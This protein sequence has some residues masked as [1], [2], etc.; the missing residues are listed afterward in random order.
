MIMRHVMESARALW[1][2]R[3]PPVTGL[4]LLALVAAGCGLTPSRTPRASG[5][6]SNGQL[7][8]IATL[9]NPVA[10]QVD[11]AGNSFMAWVGPD[12]ELHFA[13]LNDRAE[14][15]AQGPLSLDT[16][17][18]LKPQLL[19]DPTGQ[20]HLTWLDRRE[21]GLQLL[22]ARLSVDGEVIQGATALSPP[23][24]RV[25]HRSIV[26]DPIGQTIELLWSDNTPIRPGCYH[27]ALDWSGAI[28]AP[29]NMLIPE[30]ILPTAQID[31][32]GFVHL[33]WKRER[34]QEKPGFHYAVYDP[35]R[36]MLGP[37]ILVSEPVAQASVI[38]RPTAG[39][40]FDGP[41]LGLDEDSVYLAWVLEV[42]EMGDVMDFTFYQAFSPP[43]LGQ[44]SGTGTFDYAPP[45]VTEEAVP[46]LGVEPSLT[47]HP[48]FLEGQP[49]RQA[50]ACY[51]EVPG[52][53]NVETLQIAMIEVQPG[54]I[55]RQEI[56][57][58][59]RGASVRPSVVLDPN[60]ELHLA[61]I[62]T[63]GF[64]RYQV[65]YASTSPQARETLNQITTYE[66]VDTVLSTLMQVLSAL[67]FVPLVLTWMFVP[68]GWLVIFA[69]VT[70][71]SEV[72]EPRAPRALVLAMLLHL[73]AKLL[74]LPGILTR[75][76]LSTLLP[77]FLRLLLGRWMLPLLLAIASAALLRAYLKRRPNQSIFSAYF[78][79]AA[80]DSLSTL[81]IYVAPLMGSA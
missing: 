12:H 22:Y 79:Y 28:V 11:E 31:R 76:P 30:G 40:G 51:T 41:W 15:V 46:V 70:H 78:I 74:F 32:Q 21:Q 71:E 7:L 19:R 34:E 77:P 50:L 68:I 17:S 73:V 1:R 66:V 36:R 58:A 62:D 69:V 10:L 67:F 43:T 18:P 44:R 2:S 65:V 23:E 47:G 39:V 8:G 45:V 14:M 29:V 56:V 49:T 54:Q 25:A 42:R 4:V 75:F 53:G 64:K 63:A 5:D 59:S 38:G 52:P 57:S 33:A 72:S 81:L 16:N 35:Q 26:L 9:N 20:L 55:E 80:V 61:W 48:R 27:T 6:W 60:D 13:R 37:D 24:L 3:L